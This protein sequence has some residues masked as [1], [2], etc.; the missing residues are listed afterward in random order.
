MRWQE[1][2]AGDPNI[3]GGGETS[4]WQHGMLPGSERNLETRL[5]GGENEQRD[6]RR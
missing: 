1:G 6:R 2:A 5:V 4:G 3:G